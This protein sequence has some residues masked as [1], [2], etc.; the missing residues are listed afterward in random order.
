MSLKDTSIEDRPIINSLAASSSFSAVVFLAA[1]GLVCTL[2]FNGN[3]ACCPQA[4]KRL[5]PR[6]R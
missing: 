2:V 5:R 4:K 3:P 6:G 1:C